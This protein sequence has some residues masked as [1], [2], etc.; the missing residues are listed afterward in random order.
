LDLPTA[1]VSDSIVPEAVER[2]KPKR[3]SAE[4]IVEKKETDAEPPAE[5]EAAEKPKSEPAE[6]KTSRPAPAPPPRRS[7]TQNNGETRTRVVKSQPAPDI[8][9]IFTG[10]TIE[11]RD[12]I[13]QRRVERRRQREQMTDEELRE[14][15]RQRRQ[16]RRERQNNQTFPF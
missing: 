9:S 3:A 2:A 8:E 4:K 16:Q 12:E 1:E 11:Q 7:Q 5:T 14:M 10:R 13:E 6:V 15:R